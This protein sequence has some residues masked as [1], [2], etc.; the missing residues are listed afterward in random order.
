VLFTPSTLRCSYAQHS[1]YFLYFFL[2]YFCT[3]RG[4]TS[5]P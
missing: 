2:T 3:F 1:T 4:P 5:A